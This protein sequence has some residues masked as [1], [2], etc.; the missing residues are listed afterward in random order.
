MSWNQISTA[1]IG[2]AALSCGFAAHAQQPAAQPGT[3]DP[4]AALTQS[5]QQGL[6]L[7]R[8]YEWVE[9][10]I[11]RL[12]GEEK[13]RTQKRCYYGPD[14]TVQKVE[15]AQ[16]P[17]A[18]EEGRGRRGGTD[19]SGPVRGRVVENKTEDMT[20]YMQRA[21]ALIH[22]Y[23]PPDAAQIQAA[24]GAGR[25][26]VSQPAGTVRVAISDYLLSG[27]SLTVDMNPTTSVLLGLGVN[28]YLD[29]PDE[30]VTLTVR[31]STLPD[32]ALYAAETTFD[33]AAKNIT[34][35]IQT[36]GYQPAAPDAPR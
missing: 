15:L 35:V 8:Q 36:S 6:A 19:R 2:A 34:V 14:G 11:I 20:E 16:P 5:M 13:G 30:S 1:I 3:P 24:K 21:A 31:M 23:V 27:D 4:V 10:T 32:G 22:Q 7:I 25:I 17:P 9:T 18:Q 29:Q 26:A 28:T 33:A 12:N